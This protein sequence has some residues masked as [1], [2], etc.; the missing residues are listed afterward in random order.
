MKSTGIVRKLDSFGRL[1]LPA[2]TRKSLDINEKDPVEFFI[3][4]D[5]MVIRKYNPACM[6]CGESEETLLFEGK[7]ICK[8]CI[9]KIADLI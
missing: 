3:D 1:V 5:K 7:L 2:E 6:F 8:S 4:G 9:K